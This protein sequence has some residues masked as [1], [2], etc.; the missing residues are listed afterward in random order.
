VKFPGKSVGCNISSEGGIVDWVFAG[1][2]DADGAGDDDGE[3]HP[4]TAAQ[5]RMKTAMRRII[6]LTEGF[7][8]G[9]HTAAERLIFFVLEKSYFSYAL[10]VMQACPRR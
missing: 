3:V 5:R 8:M 9:M 10:G 6:W 2:G 1:T 4:A 7:V